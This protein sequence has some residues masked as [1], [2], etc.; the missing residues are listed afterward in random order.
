MNK[1]NKKYC[2]KVKLSRDDYIWLK[3]L[4]KYLHKTMDS[5]L[6]DGA[7][8][9]YQD[10]LDSKERINGRL[11]QWIFYEEYSNTISKLDKKNKKGC[12]S[13]WLLTKQR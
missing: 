3:L 7:A 13:K 6:A 11:V 9:A 1:T 10:L 4:A 12:F 2:V 5:I 8:S